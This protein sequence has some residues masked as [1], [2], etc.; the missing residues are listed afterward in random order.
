MKLITFQPFSALPFAGIRANQTLTVNVGA[1][2]SLAEFRVHVRG[3][4]VLLAAPP[5][6]RPGQSPEG[7][8]RRV[9]EVPRAVCYLGWQLEPGDKLDELSKYSPPC[10]DCGKPITLDEHL[11]CAVCA[12]KPK[13]E[14]AEPE[15]AE[16]VLV[17]ERTDGETEHSVRGED[18]DRFSD[19]D[20]REMP[21]GKRR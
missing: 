21:R 6:W 13:P 9:F 3:P 1:A 2:G 20:G 7:K 16:P 15:G 5:G 17:V 10:D 18:S 11:L 14:P 12:K 4:S 19:N 8:Q